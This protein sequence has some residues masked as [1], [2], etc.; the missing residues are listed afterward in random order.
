[1]KNQLAFAA[2]AAAFAIPSAAS[3]AD[4]KDL[5]AIRAEV[6]QLKQDYENRLSALERRLQEAEAATIEAQNAARVAQQAAAPAAPAAPVA[7]PAPVA[8]SPTAGNVFNPD[9]SLVLG[10]TLSNLSQDPDSWAIAGFVPAGDEVGPGKRGFSLGESELTM[11]ANIDPNFSGRLT[12]ALTDEGTAEVEEAYVQT[13]ARGAGATARAGRFLSAVGYQNGQHAH[14]WDF[15]D[16]PLA[17]QAFLGG[18]YKVDGLQAKWLAPTDTFL[19]LGA[20]LGAGDSFPGGGRNKNGFGASALFAHAGGDIGD[21]ASWRAGVAHLRARPEGRTFEEE[22]GEAAF[23]GRSALWIADAVYKWAPGG[24]PVERNFKLQGEYFQRKESGDLSLADASG[25]YSSK[26]SGWYVQGVYQ[27]MRGW[28]AGLRHDRLDS[29]VPTIGAGAELFPSLAAYKPQRS[30]V[31]V[32]YS[33]SEFSRLRLQ[34]AQ[35][36]ARNGATDNQLFL[37]YVMSLGAHAAHAF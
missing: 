5:A 4:D 3:A 36:K 18:Q 20:E 29:G 19:E 24:N 35:D 31:M 26:Q 10:G 6:A 34:F 33:P 25:A 2:L 1:M 14:T 37:Q 8:S 7:P 28:R 32:D 11:S 13:R 23:T 17:Y 16:A 15:V 12:F 27:F 9:I 30:S 22:G 21:S